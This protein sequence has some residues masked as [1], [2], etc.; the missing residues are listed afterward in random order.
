[1]NHIMW[2][3]TG[4]PSFWGGHCKGEHV[5]VFMK[6]CACWAKQRRGGGKLLEVAQHRKVTA[7][8]MPLT[9][10]RAGGEVLYRDLGQ[11]EI[12]SSCFKWDLC[13]KV[14]ADLHEK[15]KYGY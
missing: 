15:F 4:I 1:M 10:S 11:G 2:G 9:H 5:C 14:P 7:Q 13:Y 6:S 3:G 8:K 12:I